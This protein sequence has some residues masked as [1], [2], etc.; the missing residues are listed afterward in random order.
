MSRD[1]SR[2]KDPL[3]KTGYQIRTSIARAVRDAVD[4]GAA[5]S[6]NAFVE[7][8]LVRELKEL[9][10]RQVYDAMRAAGV[11]VQVHYIPVHLQPYYRAL[12]FKP[13]QCPEAER[14]SEEALS[15][16]LYPALSDREQDQVVAV[17]RK[18]LA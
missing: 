15:L 2:A 12:G 11:G 18:A 3:K 1:R 9:R 10:R 5:P 17:L 4:Q 6:Q 13:G 14:Y 16:P 7:Q 8:A